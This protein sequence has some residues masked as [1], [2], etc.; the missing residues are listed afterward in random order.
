VYVEN[1]YAYLMLELGFPGLLLWVFFLLWV[2]VPRR[3]RA[4]AQWRV[5]LLCTR[6]LVATFLT[7][8]LIGTGLFVSIPQ[9]AMVLLAMGWL[10]AREREPL[11]EATR[12][13]VAVRRLPDR[14]AG[15]RLAVDG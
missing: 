6:V 3:M 7:I 12:A 11:A 14:L 5:A 8:G 13:L 2:L 4:N 10:A 9:S 1:H 15:D